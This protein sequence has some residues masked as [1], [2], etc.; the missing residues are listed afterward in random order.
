MFLVFQ[1]L[2]QA[3]DV[4]ARTVRSNIHHERGHP[5]QMSE[6]GMDQAGFLPA[7]ILLLLIRVTFIQ[8]PF[9]HKTHLNI[10]L[11]CRMIYSLITVT[12]A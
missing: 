7:L 4:W 5:E 12:A 3:S 8:V 1:V 10:I 11:S 6:R 9:H 2:E